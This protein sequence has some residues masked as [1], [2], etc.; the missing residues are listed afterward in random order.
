MIPILGWNDFV[1]VLILGGEA[2]KRMPAALAGRVARAPAL[3][4]R[5]IKIPACTVPRPLVAEF[6]RLD[7][8]VDAT[9]YATF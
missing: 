8:T 6:T 1:Y 2:A 7:C 5:L 9:G 4:G 3:I